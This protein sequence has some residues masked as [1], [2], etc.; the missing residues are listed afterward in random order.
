M[1]IRLGLLFSHSV[2]TR[3]PHS[4]AHKVY[5]LIAFLYSGLPGGI[6]FPRAEPWGRQSRWLSPTARKLREERK[7]VEDSKI[8]D[9][10]ALINNSFHLK[11]QILLFQG[12]FYQ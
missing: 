3:L 10:L 6:I 12:A 9:T 2:P 5:W 7:S 1:M 4:G 8:C 11:W